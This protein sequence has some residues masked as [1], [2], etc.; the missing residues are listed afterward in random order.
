MIMLLP[1]ILALGVIIHVGVGTGYKIKDGK[2]TNEL[3]I[4][5]ECIKF[6]T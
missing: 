6:L 5:P 1:Y 3:S 2:E 4:V